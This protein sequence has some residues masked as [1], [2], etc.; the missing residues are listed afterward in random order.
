M[1]G[2][3]ILA[4]YG[5]YEGAYASRNPAATL[6]PDTVVGPTDIAVGRFGFAAPGTGQVSNVYTPG[7]L[8]G[9]VQPRAGLWSLTYWQAGV[10]YLRAGKPVTLY[11]SGDFY[12]R[13]PTGAIIGNPVYTDPSTG[14]AYAADGG[15]FLL[16]PWRV[17]TNIR[18]YCLGIVS[19]YPLT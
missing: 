14:I 8:Y 2:R 13:F 12:L 1:F 16:T 15:G 19:P 4:P 11:T 9:I 5:I 7:D 18:P 3:R 10:R 17:V 6:T